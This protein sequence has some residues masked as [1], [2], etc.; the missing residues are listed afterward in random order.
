MQTMNQSLATLVK[1]RRISMDAAVAVSSMPDE[2]RD[3]V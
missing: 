1:L 3:L 2:L